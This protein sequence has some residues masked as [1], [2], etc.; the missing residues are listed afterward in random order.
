MASRNKVSNSLCELNLN[1]QGLGVL[2]K[3][4]L[5]NSV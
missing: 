1:N 3:E 2:N 4:I 5:H